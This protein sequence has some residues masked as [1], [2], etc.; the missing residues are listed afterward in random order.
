MA[1]TA[2]VAALSP[3]SQETISAYRELKETGSI[4]IT[5]PTVVEVPFGNEVLERTNFA[6]LDE[7][8]DTFQPYFFKQETVTNKIPISVTA[9]GALSGTAAKMIDGNVRTYSEFVLPEDARGNIRIVVNSSR[10]ITSSSLTLLLDSHVALPTSIEIRAQVNGRDTIVVAR[11]PITQS[12]VQF[13]RTTTARWTI[14]LTYS[15]PLRIAELKLAQENH[16]V[17]VRRMS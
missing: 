4:P 10:A 12:T 9:I 5:V 8:T 13:P 7:T 6:V 1:A 15:Q 17:L 3:V 16:R 14:T 11:R 2:A